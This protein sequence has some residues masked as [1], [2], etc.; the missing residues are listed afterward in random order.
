MNA[1]LT[2]AAVVDGGMGAWI[3]AGAPVSAAGNGGVWNG[4]SVWSPA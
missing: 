2:G 4:K 3:A 1:G